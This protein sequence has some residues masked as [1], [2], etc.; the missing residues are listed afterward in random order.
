MWSAMSY[1]WT[2]QAIKVSSLAI[3]FIRMENKFFLH[4]SPTSYILRKQEL[5]KK[6]GKDAK[7][8]DLN[9]ECT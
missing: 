3:M 8:F 6:R 2:R 4:Q 5:K 1:Y 7:Y 9:I